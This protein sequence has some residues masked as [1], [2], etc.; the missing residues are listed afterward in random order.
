MAPKKSGGKKKVVSNR[1]FSTVSVPRKKDVE[2]E[3]VVVEAPAVE[4]VAQELA[5]QAQ[6][7]ED[8]WDPEASE[9]HEFQALADKIRLGSDKEVARV[10]KVSRVVINEGMDDR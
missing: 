6:G 8:E 1:G 3:Q 9:R 4:E 7:V 10:S 2:E 5:P